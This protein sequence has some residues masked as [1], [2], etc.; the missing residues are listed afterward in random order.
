MDLCE[1]ILYHVNFCSIVLGSTLIFL[2]VVVTGILFLFVVIYYNGLLEKD[3]VMRI[4]KKAAAKKEL[5]RLSAIDQDVLTVLR[6]SRELY[7]LGL[8]DELNLDRPQQLRFSSLYPALDRLLDRGLLTVRW[9]DEN[10][11]SGG[12]RRKYYKITAHGSD[13]LTAVEEYRESLSE[14]ALAT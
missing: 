14:K 2:V 5:P 3:R 6:G 10:D 9:G 13:A 1:G 4:K 7:G 11:P 12:A 8:L